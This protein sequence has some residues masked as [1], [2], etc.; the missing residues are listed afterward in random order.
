[1]WKRYLGA[2]STALDLVAVWPPGD[3]VDL[4]DFGYLRK[5]RFLRDGNI[6]ILPESSSLP[7]EVAE[8]KIAGKRILHG[9]LARDGKG[10]VQIAGN[11]ASAALSTRSS[12]LLVEFDSKTKS[13]KQPAK[14]GTCLLEALGPDWFK[15]YCVVSKVHSADRFH[16]LISQKSEREVRIE[17]DAQ[18]LHNLVD[19]LTV[20]VDVTSHSGDLFQ[21]CSGPMWV[22]LLGYRRRFFKPPELFHAAEGDRPAE[23]HSEELLKSQILAERA[24]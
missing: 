12:I 24:G 15:K 10:E 1:M 19:G 5:G 16:V 6:F 20:G 18:V 14:L 9:D 17:A 4:G 7:L 22:G 2:F 3:S 23:L 8:L 11:G 21:D 13:L